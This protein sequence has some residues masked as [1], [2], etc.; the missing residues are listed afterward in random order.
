MK[1]EAHKEALA[2]YLAYVEQARH[3]L[4]SSK[5]LLLLVCS[6]AASEAI[7]ILLHKLEL[8]DDS[9]IIKHNQLD[10]KNFWAELPDFD[11]KTKISRLAAEVERARN[12]AYGTLKNIK[13]EDLLRNISLL[14]ELK[15]LVEA[16]GH[17]K[18]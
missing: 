18:L 6:Q 7:S 11:G 16:A 17:E 1:I 2:E 10:S 14:F 5:R 8:I 13:P 9:T 12:L 15:E 3:T 4:E